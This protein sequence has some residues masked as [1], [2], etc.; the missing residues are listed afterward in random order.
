[1][2][3]KW[4][5]LNNDDYSDDKIFVF[6]FH[7][8]GGMASSF[9]NWVE[10]NDSKVIFVPIELP[11]KG[12]RIKEEFVANIDK[13]SVKAAE[14]ISKFAKNNRYVLY[15]HSMGAAI[16]FKCAYRLRKVKNKPMA[17]IVSGRYA[18]CCNCKEA[19]RPGMADSVLVNELR[20]MKKTPKQILDNKEILK[21]FLPFIKQDYCLNDSFEYNKEMLDIPVIVYS[22]TEDDKENVENMKEWQ[23]ITTAKME[24]YECKG[25]H[26]FIFDMGQIYTNIL[27]MKVI[28][29][30]NK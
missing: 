8:A 21:V 19:Y 2:N 3:N 13:V 9:R 5:P 26:F 18:P 24:N 15:G 17:L 20:R 12:S 23:K 25:S 4:F 28:N 7:H 29:L 10:K 6:C 16:A 11:G 30:S 1:M 14:A 22:G 27:K